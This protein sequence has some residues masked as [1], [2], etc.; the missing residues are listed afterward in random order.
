MNACGGLGIFL[1]NTYEK[2]LD[3]PRVHHA[4]L[5]QRKGVSRCRRN[6]FDFCLIHPVRL[7]NGVYLLD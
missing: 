5:A 1:G 2:N 6:L 7:Q 3:L 4:F